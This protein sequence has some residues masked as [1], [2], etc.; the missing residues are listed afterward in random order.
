MFVSCE[1]SKGKKSQELI[2]GNAR[3]LSAMFN[4]TLLGRDRESSQPI[5]LILQA[6]Q[7]EIE[8]Y[9]AFIE[10]LAAEEVTKEYYDDKGI[11]SKVAECMVSYTE[12][13]EI[14][15]KAVTVLNFQEIFENLEGVDKTLRECDEL[16]YF[17]PEC[18][19]LANSYLANSEMKLK[20]YSENYERLILQSRK[21]DSLI[22]TV[23]S[24]ESEFNR[25]LARG[26][27][28]LNISKSYL[29]SK[30]DWL[31]VIL[32]ELQVSNPLNIAVLAIQK[33]K[34]ELVDTKPTRSKKTRSVVKEYEKLTLKCKVIE[35]EARELYSIQ[36]NTIQ[37]MKICQPSIAAKTTG[38]MF[39]A[40]DRTY[41]EVRL[42]GDQQQYFVPLGSLPR[43]AILE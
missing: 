27:D 18:L 39:S 33:R 3:K 14:M 35:L 37:F 4:N 12:Q 40:Y 23:L 30:K 32:E 6:H 26:Q 13:R 20:E 8:K 11:L 41:A 36:N 31:T 16:E 28:S 17:G 42:D 5:N 24:M 43:E 38:Q 19:D 15:M 7:T 1:S 9:N 21:L 29:K 34:T 10:N 25:S 2:D 22:S